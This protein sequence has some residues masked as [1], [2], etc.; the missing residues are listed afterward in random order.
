MKKRYEI[1]SFFGKENNNYVACN[2]IYKDNSLNH[3]IKD[4][5]YFLSLEG[6]QYQQL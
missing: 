6:L 3:L 2:D 5:F 4:N 1:G